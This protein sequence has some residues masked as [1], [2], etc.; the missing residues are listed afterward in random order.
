MTQWS[1]GERADA[2]QIVGVLRE[3]FARAE[4]RASRE[5]VADYF[6]AVGAQSV[7]DLWGGGLSADALRAAMPDAT[8]VSVENGSVCDTE[9]FVDRLG[10]RITKPRLRRA[11]LIAADEGGYEA[12]WGD[13]NQVL[14]ERF[15]AVWLDFCA[16]WH[17]AMRRL[18][19]RAGQQCEHLAV[20]VMPE[21]DG[22]GQMGYHDRLIG[23]GAILADYAR[24]PAAYIG[25]YRRND[26]GQ[27]MALFIFDSPTD[28]ARVGPELRRRG[29]W[30]APRFD[31][32]R[33][34]LLIRCS[35]C[36][37]TFTYAPTSNAT[38]ANSRSIKVCGPCKTPQPRSKE[39]RTCHQSIQN[40]KYFYCSEDCARR[41]RVKD[42]PPCQIC[43]G[44]VPAGRRTLCSS[45]CEQMRA[46]QRADVRVDRHA[47]RATCQ[48]CGQEF[49]RV[50]YGPRRFCSRRCRRA[51][52][53]V[54]LLTTAA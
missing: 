25:S 23:L 16:Q 33:S 3:K 39:C 35:K 31:K 2:H 47:Q 44:R 46:H 12:A 7:L 30:S 20:T 5:F 34:L 22:L 28:P 15:D 17:P 53:R 43:G 50:Q 9:W 54:T 4:K 10:H 38:T 18:V 51:N 32:R 52:N 19:E 13:A 8:I 48:R 24:M 26:L 40:G 11:H 42:K 41:S 1:A 6:R 21:R 29:F 49:Q 14:A 36:H 37:D 27:D 45:K